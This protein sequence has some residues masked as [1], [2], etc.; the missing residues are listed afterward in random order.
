MFWMINLELGLDIVESSKQTL[1]RDHDVDLN[2]D[3]AIEIQET[4]PIS[5]AIKERITNA[6]L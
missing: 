1:K 6:K 4:T 2:E 5:I 3:D